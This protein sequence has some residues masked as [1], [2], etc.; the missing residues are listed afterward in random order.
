MKIAICFSG[1]TRT[2]EKCWKSYDQ[3]LDK[4]DCDLF[5]ATTPNDLLHKYPFKKVLYQ[6]DENIPDRWHTINT[7]PQSV[8]QN[9]LRQF[10]YIDL[11]NEL[12]REYEQDKG[13]KYDFVFR[14]R[15]DN[16]ILG[17]MPELSECN[18]ENIYIPSG[19]DHPDFIPNFGISDRFAFGGDRVMNIYCD[20]ISRLDEYMKDPEAWYF[21]EVVLRWCLLTKGVTI[22]RFY[23]GVKIMRENGKLA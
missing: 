22:E 15:F 10:Y 3:L 23:G 1:Q 13:I 8:Q 14:T 4:Y 20:K 6:E 17:D 7:N 18:P 9:M 11:A 16:I 2:F 19:D 5:G 12:R 21:A